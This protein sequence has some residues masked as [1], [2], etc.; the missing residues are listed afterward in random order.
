MSVEGFKQL[1]DKANKDELFV[2]EVAYSTDEVLKQYDISPE[3]AHLFKA[4]K[5]DGLGLDS[6]YVSLA[7]RLFH[8]LLG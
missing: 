2:L 8:N 7:Q 6:K 4:R 3:E 5:F 1:I